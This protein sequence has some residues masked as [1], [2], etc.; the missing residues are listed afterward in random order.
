M[1]RTNSILKLV[2]LTVFCFSFLSA[3][4]AFANPCNANDWD[5]NDNVCMKNIDLGIMLNDMGDT[6]GASDYFYGNN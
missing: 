4:N 3:K 2:L 5:F 1:N 6:E